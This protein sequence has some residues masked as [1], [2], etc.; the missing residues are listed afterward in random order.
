MLF[1]SGGNSRLLLSIRGRGRWDALVGKRNLSH[2]HIQ[3]QT[4]HLVLRSNHRKW[5]EILLPFLIHNIICYWQKRRKWKRKKKKYDSFT[6]IKPFHL[7][8]PHIP[9]PWW[10]HFNYAKTSTILHF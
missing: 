10:S 2:N 5:Y 7:F 3:T 6:F 9:I 8:S 4:L 1:F